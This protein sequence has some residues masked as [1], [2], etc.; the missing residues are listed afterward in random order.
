M[1]GRPIAFG[2]RG[3]FSFQVA[4]GACAAEAHAASSRSYSSA[5]SCHS[6]RPVRAAMNWRIASFALA[7]PV[8]QVVA[9]PQIV[10]LGTGIRTRVA[11]P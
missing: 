3:V 9:M 10:R 1:E 8:T 2:W 6:G 11:E 7:A 5:S 4:L